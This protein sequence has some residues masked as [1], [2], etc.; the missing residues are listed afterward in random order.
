MQNIGK[1]LFISY[2]TEF[3]NFREND[4]QWWKKNIDSSVTLIYDRK[5]QTD[6]ILWTGDCI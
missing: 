4:L 5:Q 2:K 6:G 1:L 3:K